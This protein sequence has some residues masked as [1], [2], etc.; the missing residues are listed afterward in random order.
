M[1]R[2]SPSFSTVSSSFS[3]DSFE[4]VSQSLEEKQ[5][6]VRNLIHISVCSA[7]ITIGG[8]CPSS[9]TCYAVRTLYN[10]IRKCTAAN[11]HVPKCG[12]YQSA[13]VHIQ[14]CSA[15]VNCRICEP[16][17]SEYYHFFKPLGG[18]PPMPPQSKS[19]SSRIKRKKQEQQEQHFAPGICS[20]SPSPPRLSLGTPRERPL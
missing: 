11:C 16:A 15:E 3:D 14:H 17:R 8:T 12:K 7:D 19:P 13:F 20:P 10:H 9:R 18:P 1:N 2:T 5:L 6:T 4:D